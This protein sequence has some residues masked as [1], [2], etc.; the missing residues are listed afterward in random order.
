MPPQVAAGSRGG[1]A[2]AWMDE[3]EAGDRKN[4]RV[5]DKLMLALPR[6]L[7]SIPGVSLTLPRFRLASVPQVAGWPVGCFR[8]A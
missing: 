3:A 5:I 2:R 6:E 7:C 4:A 8:L 1:A